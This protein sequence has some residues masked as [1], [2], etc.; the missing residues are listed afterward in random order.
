[1]GNTVAQLK[2]TPD[3]HNLRTE[4]AD[5]TTSRSG[6]N[7]PNSIDR[8]QRLIVIR[9]PRIAALRRFTRKIAAHAV[10]SLEMA[11]HRFD[12]GTSPELAFDL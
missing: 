10:L 11:D 3:A 2:L 7:V 1:L 12:G 9:T 5:C 6:A 4:I 8:H